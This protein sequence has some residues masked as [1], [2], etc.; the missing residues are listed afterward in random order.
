MQ[1]TGTAIIK[2]SVVDGFGDAASL[3]HTIA[4]VPKNADPCSVFVTIPGGLNTIGGAVDLRMV[5]SL[6]TLRFTIQDRDDPRTEHHRIRV[7]G[8]GTVSFEQD[9]TLIS[10]VIN[11]RTILLE[12]DTVRVTVSDSTG[13]TFTATVPLLFLKPLAPYEVDSLKGWYE[14]SGKIATSDTT[15][16]S[17]VI[18]RVTTW[19]ALLPPLPSP[20]GIL[21]GEGMLR[22]HYIV[23]D[24]G[25]GFPV[26]RFDGTACLINY[27]PHSTL[28]GW[29]I[30]PFT[31]FIAAL[32]DT[33]DTTANR[34][35]ISNDSSGFGL[36]VTK[37]GEVGL[38]MRN[39]SVSQESTSGLAV[40]QDRLSLFTFS[41]TG[42]TGAGVTIDAWLDGAAAKTR[43]ALNMAIPSGYFEIGAT[44]NVQQ[45]LANAWKGDIAEI[46]VYQRVLTELDRRAVERYIQWKYGL[47]AK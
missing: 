35:L 3:Y 29:H 8:P 26:V 11:P 4:V 10:F 9:S 44:S 6:V 7:D 5:D 32:V 36:G 12:R 19:G 28:N 17:G 25:S 18:K 20:D 39:G 42:A 38:F 31:I 21:Y 15:T 47:I 27:Y 40:K 22:P 37:K 14:A 23:P 2:F 34:A 45:D 30:R 24:G 16:T 46:I 33:L 41:S 43:L 1:D 13:T